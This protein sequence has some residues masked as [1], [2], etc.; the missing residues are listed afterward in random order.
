MA[1]TFAESSFA[2]E[3]RISRPCGPRPITAQRTGAPADAWARASRPAAPSPNVRPRAALS[4]R[5]SRRF[6]GGCY[7][8][9][10]VIG[11][12][13]RRERAPEQTAPLRSKEG[14]GTARADREGALLILPA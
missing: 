7:L 10:K 1:R 3:A 8:S 13:K 6:M 14:V 11:R 9:G 2:S 12:T 4:R 5:N